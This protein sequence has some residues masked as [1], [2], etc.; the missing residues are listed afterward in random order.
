MSAAIE[1]L[2]ELRA[3]GV[4]I[5]TRQHGGVRF[6]PARLIDAG[7]LARIH[8]HKPELLAHFRVEQ[9]EAEIDRLSGA[10]G[11]RTLPESGSRAYSIVEECQEHG[12]ALVISTEDVRVIS[13]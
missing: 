8:A 3:R 9:E 4:R 12:V 6:T 1:I 7:L 5:Q 13:T 2:K 10:D 11:W